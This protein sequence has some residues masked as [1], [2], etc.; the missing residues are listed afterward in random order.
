MVTRR[1]WITAAAAAVALG[2]ARNAAAAPV[3][4]PAVVNVQLAL[5]LPARHRRAGDERGAGL[6]PRPF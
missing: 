4:V 3:L 2:G 6:L 5:A 1:A